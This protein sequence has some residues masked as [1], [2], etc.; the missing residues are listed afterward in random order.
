MTAPKRHHWW[1][2][3][4]S[5]HWTDANQQ[6]GVTRPDGKSFRTSPLNIGV[7]SELYT[8][9]GDD[10]AKDTSI[11]EWFASA[12]DGPANMAISF[13]ADPSGAR[14]VPFPGAEEGK[15]TL[16]ALGF[17]VKPYVEV[18]ELPA[19]IRIAISK[20]L[21]ALLVRHPRYLAKLQDFHKAE[22][23]AAPNRDVA[24]FNM[25]RMYELYADRIA[26]SV[27]MLF[28]RSGDAEFL[29]GDGGLSVDEPWRSEH[30]IPFDIHAPL[31]PDLSIEVL[32]TPFDDDLSRLAVQDLTNQGVAR[33][34]KISLAQATR[35]V[36]SRQTAPISFIKR[37]FGVP[38]PKNIGYRIMNGRLETKYDPSMK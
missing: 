6:V 34:N 1:P 13:L 19:E 8:R 38:A 17:V 9:F 23:P 20:Y 33:F 28:R 36:F 30:A 29:Y 21:A 18:V 14:R 32:P 22:N 11:E 26:K 3:V 4:Q 2:L 5:R 24:L 10:D 31:T 12:I 27:F 35:F 15:Q 16:K 37:Y 7:E 25:L